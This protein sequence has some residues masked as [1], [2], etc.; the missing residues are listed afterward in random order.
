MIGA[1]SNAN[2]V[3]SSVMK[4]ANGIGQSKTEAKN[5]S[6]KV[7]QNGQSVSTK[8]H[9]ISSTQNLRTMT[10]QY[11]EY[12]KEEYGNK[13][14]EHINNDTVKDFIDKKAEEVGEG[15][16][17]TYISTLGKMADNLNEQGINTIDRESITDYR[18]D[19]KEQGHSLQSEHI[20][21]GYENPSEIVEKMNDTPFGISAQLQHE[22]GLRADD[23]LNSEKWTLNDDKTLSIEGS[24]G[25]IDYTTTT[26]TD[27]LYE[28]VQEAI[29][30]NY[31]GNYEEY[32]E[33]LKEAV[34]DEYN[35]TH[36]LRY[37]FAQERLEELRESNYSE[38]EALSELSL[39]MGHSRSEISLHY[40]TD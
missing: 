26:L 32:R 10:T 25:G 31:K 34:G 24:K 33:A 15:T 16:L 40:L 38:N 29:E 18:N 9:S 12:L 20:N 37:N 7:G 39:E 5:N 23:A 27:S 28:K 17:N 2:Y 8:A 4:N 14:V 36:G 21:R 13:I 3:V 19:L 6:E 1:R 11:T 30:N 35:G 22:V